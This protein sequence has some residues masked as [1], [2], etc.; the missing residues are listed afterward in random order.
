M[1]IIINPIITEKANEASEELNRYTFNVRRDANKV[2][3]KKAIEALY[4]VNVE[5]V[6]TAIMPAKKVS[7]MTKAGFIQGSTG[8]WKKAVVEVASGEIID[9]YSNL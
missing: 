6:R 1:D 5:K 2:E 8:S 3:I 7:R 9:L 4:G